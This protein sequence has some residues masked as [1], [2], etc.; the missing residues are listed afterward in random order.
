[1]HWF[2]A[3]FV[4]VLLAGRFRRNLVLFCSEFSD[5]NNNCQSSLGSF[6]SFGRNFP[7]EKQKCKQAVDFKSV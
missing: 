1:M 3:A 2:F 5:A 4:Y 7:L 6:E